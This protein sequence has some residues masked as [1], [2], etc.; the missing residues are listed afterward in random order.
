MAWIF[1]QNLQKFGGAGDPSKIQLLVNTLTHTRT[2]QKAPIMV[3]G[4]TEISNAG[5]SVFQLD[6]LFAA[7]LLDTAIIAAVGTTAVAGQDEFISIGWNSDLLPVRRVGVVQIRDANSYDYEDQPYQAGQG[8]YH[9]T[10]GGATDSRGL[11]YIMG[12]DE[13][14]K[15]WVFGFMHNVY[16][17]GDKTRFPKDLGDITYALSTKFNAAS[18][19]LGG[20]FNVLPVGQRKNYGNSRAALDGLGP[21]YLDTTLSNAYDWWYVNDVKNIRPQDAKLGYAIEDNTYGPAMLFPSDHR[22]ILLQVRN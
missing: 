6:K 9:F 17:V 8:Q 3:A 1:H 13:K 15:N 14:K 21:A 19:V 16:T 4:F 11:L 10:A 20:D 22:P 18:V 2:R 5:A 7:L 12:Q